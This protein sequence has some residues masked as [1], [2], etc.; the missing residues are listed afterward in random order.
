MESTMP[1]MNELMREYER[2]RFPPERQLDLQGEG[3]RSARDRALH[4]IQSRAHEDP[5][6]ELLLIVERGVRPGRPPSPV[7][8]EVRKLLEE[9][10]GRLIDWWQPFAPGSLALRTAVEPRMHLA[11][12]RA[13]RPV[14]GEGRTEETAGAAHPPAR[15]DI[16]PELLERVERTAELRIERES[17][18]IRLLD[19][20]LRE[21]WIEI[22]AEAMERRISFEAALQRVWEAEMRRRRD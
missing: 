16:P 6:V 17:L 3:P 18:S 5:G 20:V 19:V 7:A 14:E 4:W 8:A 10:E 11:P 12:A 22:Q 1:G 15:D 9:L 2:R 21:V 13:A